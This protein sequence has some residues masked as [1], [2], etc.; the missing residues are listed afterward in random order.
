MAT[1]QRHHRWRRHMGCLQYIIMIIALVAILMI[2]TISVIPP[3]Y[4]EMQGYFPLGPGGKI[5]TICILQS[6]VQN[7]EWVYFVQYDPHG[8]MSDKKTQLADGNGMHIQ[9]AIVLY[10]PYMRYLAGLQSGI[11]L[12]LLQ[13]YY[14]QANSNVTKQPTAIPLKGGNDAEFTQLQQYPATV[15]TASLDDSFTPP[16]D[17]KTYDI[18]TSDRGLTYHLAAQ[19]IKS[20]AINAS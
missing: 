10:P 6:N 17:G 2:I 7:K 16:A 4:D 3:L 15:V 9:A 19:Q 8:K 14:Q 18:Y 13:A 20:C 1:S 5:A 11:K 12:T